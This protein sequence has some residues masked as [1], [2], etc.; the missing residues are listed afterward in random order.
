MKNIVANSQIQFH[1]A[2]I[3]NSSKITT[4]NILQRPLACIKVLLQILYDLIV[5]RTAP[6]TSIYLFIV[7]HG[8]IP[9][10][11]GIVLV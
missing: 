9:H 6:V 10:S 11:I 8:I 3:L 5:S 2:M 1:H 7:K 4:K